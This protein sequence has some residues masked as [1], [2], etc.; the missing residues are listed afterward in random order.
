M[1]GINLK[2]GIL[3][4]G[5]SLSDLSKS[6]GI[7]P[8]A[9]NSIL[10]ANDVRSG[11]IEKLCDVLNVDICYFYE[12]TKY[13]KRSSESVDPTTQTDKDLLIANLRG[14]IE[15]YKVALGIKGADID[16]IVNAV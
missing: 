4:K 10:K 16:S 2:N 6:L 12:G 7:T 3:R 11:T 13:L 15:A 14:Q 5:I 8:Q 9:L 1:N